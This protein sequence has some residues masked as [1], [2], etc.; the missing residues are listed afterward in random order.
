MPTRSFKVVSEF[1]PGLFGGTVLP[2]NCF[3]V[4]V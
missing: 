2:W 4:E 3:T 1:Y